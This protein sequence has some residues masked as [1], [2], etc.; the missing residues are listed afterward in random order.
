MNTKTENR[1]L[2]KKEILKAI[3][4][5][6]NDEVII[7]PTETIYGLSLIFNEKNQDLLNKLKNS[8]K[9]KKLI[10][11]ISSIK[12]AKQLGLLYNKYHIKIIKKCKTP[13]TVL[14]K[15]KNDELIGIRMPKRKDL[16][17]I[18][19]VVGPILSTSVNKTGSSYLTKY[20]D[21]EIFV[22]Q[23][24][25]IKKLYWVGELNNRPSSVINFDF[26]VIRK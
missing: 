3:E 17:K 11:L 14:L 21:L 23:N 24:K 16:K 5:L 25:E 8:D 20:K 26:E 15:D 7:L 13:T 1:L 18:I 6:N 12:Q 9:N 10:V 2:K 19:K 22:K 4:H